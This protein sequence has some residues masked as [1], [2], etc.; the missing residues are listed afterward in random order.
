MRGPTMT[1]NF[2]PLGCGASERFVP[3]TSGTPLATQIIIFTAN[4]M[5][6]EERKKANEVA[7]FIQLMVISRQVPVAIAARQFSCFRY[8]VFFP[9]LLYSRN[10]YIVCSLELDQPKLLRSEC[11]P[12]LARPLFRASSSPNP[13]SSTR[14]AFMHSPFSAFGSRTQIKMLEGRAK[15]INHKTPK[16]EE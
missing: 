11:T 5:E 8:T 16:M 7:R 10:F 3:R 2:S 6:E 12:S 4:W 15:H 13:F 1:V 9:P 14:T